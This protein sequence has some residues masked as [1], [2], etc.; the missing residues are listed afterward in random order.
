M[1]TVVDSFCQLFAD[2]AKLFRNVNVR[3]NEN[4]SRL[5]VD[6]NNMSEWSIKW[7]LLFNTGKC[8]VLHIGNNNPNYQYKMNGQKLKQIKEEKDLGVIVDDELKFH[9]QT[10]AAVKK[11]NSRLGLI[12]KSF[13]VL[14]QDTL[15][16]LYCPLVRSHLEY[17]NVIWGPFYKGDIEA[18][19]RVQRRATK[20]VQMIKE[21]SYEDRLRHLGLPS[22]MHRRRR[23]DMIY[24]YKIF[25]GVVDIDKDDFFETPVST[26]RGHQYKILK[27]KANKT[28][29]VNTFSN[30]IIDDWNSLPKQ[31][32]SAGSVNRFKNELDAH[33]SEEIYATPF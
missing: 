32:V 12:K 10:A 29:R 21:M 8:K 5:Q 22:L 17:G 24:T 27:K 33:W 31:V 6:V 14:D 3:E 20:Q 1:P 16:L 9:K 2:D 25:T 7:Q 11:A 28:S 18:V 13:A 23:G 15:P 4:T 26:T 19:E 30:R